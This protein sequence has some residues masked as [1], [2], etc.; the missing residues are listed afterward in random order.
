MTKTIM[1]PIDFK[2]ES[3]NT[4]KLALIEIGDEK[5]NVL[6]VYAEKLS[7][8]ITDL[9][10][11]SPRKSMQSLINKDFEEALNIINNRFE[12]KINHLEKAFFHGYNVNALVNY[13]EANNV[14]QIYIPK[15]Y[16]LKPKGK[17]FDPTPLIRKSK[18]NFKEMSWEVESYEREENQLSSLFNFS[19]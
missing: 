8:S 12:K 19:S 11:Y 4:L 17:G 16:K 2:I 15:E 13:T 6:L 7:D 18:L 1:I 3:L 5:V 10:F 14:S 9:L